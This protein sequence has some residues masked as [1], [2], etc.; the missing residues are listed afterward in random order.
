MTLS[1]TTE[2]LT[3]EPFSTRDLSAFVRYRQ[4]PEVARFQTWDTSYSLEQ[5]RALIESQ[6]SISFPASGN[7]L[8]LAIRSNETSE[9]LGD[10]ALHTLGGPG[11][12]ELGFSLA[13]ENQ[14][15]GIAFEAA[16]ALLEHLFEF[17]QATRVIA[18]TDTRNKPSKNLLRKLGLVPLPELSW[19]EQF[20]GETV[21][22]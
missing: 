1:L 2:R 14:G 3:I 6:A 12:F 11:H 16:S 13:T 7:W 4:Q 18:N 17:R 20:K 15:Q 9:L 5:G 8:Q 10:L 21:T 19:V 22:V